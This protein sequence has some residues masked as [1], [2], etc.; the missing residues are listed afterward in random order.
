MDDDTP[1]RRARLGATTLSAAAL[2][3]LSFG[4]SALALSPSAT[5]A[6]S[7]PPARVVVSAPAAA[8]GAT[9]PVRSQAEEAAGD[10]AAAPG[11]CL[12]AS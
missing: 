7:S 11:A 3:V 4:P 1:P 9:A 6:T 5:T 2:L 8:A 12:A 10:G